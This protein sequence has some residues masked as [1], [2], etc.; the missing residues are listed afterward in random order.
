MQHQVGCVAERGWQDTG[1]NGDGREPW[2]DTACED[3]H[4]AHRE[5]P[6]PGRGSEVRGLGMGNPKMS[7]DPLN[8]Y[9]QEFAQE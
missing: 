8:C 9:H 5:G 2:M 7:L 4:H 1:S 3:R 6:R